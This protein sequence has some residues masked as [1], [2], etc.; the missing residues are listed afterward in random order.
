MRG[1]RASL[2][3]AV[4]AAGL[5]LPAVIASAAPTSVHL[6][7]TV[8]LGGAPEGVAV[9]T[10]THRVYIAD[11]AS[12]N[13]DVVNGTTGH[14]ITTVHTGVFPY[15]VAVDSTRHLVFALDY[16][17]AGQ[18][19]VVVVSGRTDKALGRILVGAQPEAMLLDPATD[20]LVVSAYAGGQG[21]LYVI[22]GRTRKV[23][24][25]IATGDEIY[26]DE[27]AFDAQNNDFYV[28]NDQNPGRLWTINGKTRG[29]RTTS[30]GEDPIGPV[31]YGNTLWL[32]T[33]T[34]PD[35]SI[36]QLNATTL[37]PT[38]T[39]VLLSDGPYVNGTYD[40]ATRT[41]YYTGYYYGED[42]DVLIERAGAVTTLSTGSYIEG[43]VLDA[44]DGDVFAIDEGPE[45]PNGGS[46]SSVLVIRGLT[47]TQ[48]IRTGN[49]DQYGAVDARS[50]RV[51]VAGEDSGTLSILQA[52]V[53]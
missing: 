48:S 26:P 42:R 40:P 11:D 10:S 50:G 23:V 36:L 12:E 41:T 32:Q 5:V 44:R 27:M 22:N 20:A 7:K 15:L 28:T 35:Y 31:A 51:F 17:N 52:P 19:P 24:H 30:V 39:P 21:R 45:L 3:T 53:R 37:A 29:V 8:H 1:R 13:L 43:L 6:V 2:L 14:L 25:E 9:D 34:D 4:I 47:Q 33:Y 49:Y 16:S 38:G 46:A 18:T